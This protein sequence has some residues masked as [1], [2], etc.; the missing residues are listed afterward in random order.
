V[1]ENVLRNSLNGEPLPLA[2]RLFLECDAEG[3]ILWM[4]APARLRLGLISKL[5]NAFRD[6]SEL[7]HFL[8]N[9]K[10][11]DTFT[12]LFHR[13]QMPPVR[14]ELAC[15]MRAAGRLLLTVYMK[16]RASD[17]LEEAGSQLYD[18]QT[19]T[20][21]NY[22]RLLR[23]QQTLDSRLQRGRRNPSA[24]ITE[25]LERE[26]ARLA[27]ELHTGAG[28]SLS[29][30]RVHVELIE[31][32]TQNL[33]Q[34]IRNSLDLIGQLTRDA[35]AEVSAV[36]R[37]LHPLDW[38]G[39]NLT[40]ALR[41][42]WNKSGIP[43][44]FQGSLNLQD[45]NPEPEYPVRVAIYRIAQEAISNVIRHSGAT[46]LSLSLQQAQNEITLTI[47]DNGKGFDETSQSE[48]G[49]LGLRAIRDQVRNL[50]G[51]LHVTS[52]AQGT[53]LEVTLPLES[54]DE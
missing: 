39:L 37:R 7:T 1:T 18:L 11:K 31:S 50:D 12:G 36:S 21:D 42:L 51:R 41:R 24:I 28:Q 45:L 8:Q 22:F 46:H 13:E 43:E 49:G 10:S 15:V 35:A 30:I 4:S 34:D 44:R 40:E 19:R 32:K 26:R 20:L 16:E 29:A 2:A 48:S 38:Q 17:Q 54:S 27:R 47:E 23:L 3:R 33:P 25:Q 9:C 14:V 6:R 52:G 5:E 53:K